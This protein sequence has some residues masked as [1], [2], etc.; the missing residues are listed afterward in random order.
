[1]DTEKIFQLVD[2]ILPF[3]ACLYHQVLPLEIEGI[4]LRLGMVMLDDSGALEYVRR[5]VGYMNYKL[6]P[7]SLSSETHY[8]T[9]SAYLNYAQAKKNNTA[10]TQ[11][12]ESPA[13]E[14]QPEPLKSAPPA[15][16]FH[17]KATFVVDTPEELDWQESYA[18]QKPEQKP[19]VMPI[20][21]KTALPILEISLKHLESS[22]ATLAKLSPPSLMKELLGRILIGG[23]GRLYF[24]RQS[25]HGRVLWSQNGVLQSVLEELPLYLFQGLLEELKHLTHLP[26]KPVQ[27]VQQVEIERLCERNRVLL[28]LRIMPGAHGEEATLQVL[29]GAALKFYQQQQLTNLSRDALGVAKQLQQKVSEIRD[30]THQTSKLVLDRSTVIPTLNQVAEI[31]EQQ[32]EDLKEIRHP[33]H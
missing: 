24:E 33:Q 2:R 20:P 4:T 13:P 7:Q 32:L 3:E 27:K 26:P 8:A 31:V 12:E 18:L 23:I 22:S 19:Q 16:G 15:S 9:L 1:V 6:A 28:R 17:D 14:P 25:Y 11:L 5:M 30:R 29:R 21:S 10:H